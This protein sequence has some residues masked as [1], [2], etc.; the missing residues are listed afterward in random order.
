MERGS[1]ESRVEIL[2]QQ[3][4][5]LKDLPQRMAT[6]EAQIVQLRTEMNGGFSALS[7]AINRMHTELIGRFEAIDRRFDAIDKR[8][9]RV[10]KRFDAMDKRL[11]SHDADLAEIKRR[12]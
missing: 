5:L 6:V 10:D 1:L 2:E 4:E 11:D 8:F 7:Y 9:E 3:V 12:I